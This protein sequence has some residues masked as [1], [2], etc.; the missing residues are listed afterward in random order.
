MNR[1]GRPDLYVCNDY[2]TKDKVWINQGDGVFREID[3]LAI[4]NMSYSSMAVDFADVNR[5]GAWDFFVTEMLSEQ[6]EGQLRQYTPTDPWPRIAGRFDDQP[7]YNRNSM[8]INRGDN[9][10]VETAF[11]SGLEASGWSWASRFLDV[12]LDGWRSAGDMCVI[13][14]TCRTWTPG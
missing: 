7:Q 13:R 12:D 14:M 4:R 1:D 9:T 11:Y 10:F 3:P 6:H 2:W 8:Y 5:D